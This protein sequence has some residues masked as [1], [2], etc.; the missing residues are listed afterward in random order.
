MLTTASLQA[1][2]PSRDLDRATAS[3]R[4]ELGLRCDLT[5]PGLVSVFDAGGT[6]LGSRSSASSRPRRSH[7]S[8]GRCLTLRRRWLHFGRFEVVPLH[9]DA[10]TAG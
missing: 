10:M 7:R 6:T 8:D 9:Y 2:V 1:F 4:D 5:V 3:Y